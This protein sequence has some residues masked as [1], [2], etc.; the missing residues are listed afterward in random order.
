MSELTDDVNLEICS[1]IAIQSYLEQPRDP[2]VKEKKDKPPVII[3]N[4]IGELS[5]LTVNENYTQDFE[6]EY[7]KEAI[8]LEEIITHQKNT[9][10]KSEENELHVSSKRELNEDTKS[11]NDMVKKEVAISEVYEK[12]VNYSMTDLPEPVEPGHK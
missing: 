1:H 11:I 4:Q 10:V 7:K 5:E 8:E 9:S 12:E 3:L 2:S 6:D